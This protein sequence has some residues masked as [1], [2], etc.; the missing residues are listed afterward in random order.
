MLEPGL[1]CEH[2]DALN[3][4]DMDAG[5]QSGFGRSW[6]PAALESPAFSMHSVLYP[7]ICMPREVLRCFLSI[8]CCFF[9]A[10]VSVF[11]LQVTLMDSAACSLSWRT[12][13]MHA[14]REGEQWKP[15][16][17]VMERKIIRIFLSPAEQAA[18][19]NTIIFLDCSWC[20]PKL[21]L[22]K[23][24]LWVI[25][26]DSSVSVKSDLGTQKAGDA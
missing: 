12:L 6:L 4:T 10:Q 5:I 20:L 14:M 16:S 18:Y 9:L 23:W 15:W 24:S 2:Q 19:Q 8:N 3:W 21:Q 17:F 1:L 25:A 26:N 22:W 7:F 11:I 13:W